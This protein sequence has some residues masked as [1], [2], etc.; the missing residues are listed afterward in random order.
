[1]DNVDFDGKP[2]NEAG[3][4]EGMGD[5]VVPDGLDTNTEGVDEPN[6]D[7]T[8]QDDEENKTFSLSGADNDKVTEGNLYS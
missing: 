6:G 4:G 8:D 1:M 7:M 2:L 5:T 3:F